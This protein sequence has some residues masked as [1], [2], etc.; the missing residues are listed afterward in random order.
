MK[1][2]MVVLFLSLVLVV[3]MLP[4]VRASG[5]ICFVGINDTIPIS[6]PAEEAPYYSGGTLYIPYT[7]FNAN[8]NGVVISN[9]VD[10]KTLVLFTRNSRLVYDLE[11]DTVT[12]EEDKTSKVTLLYKNGILFIPA[13]QAASHFGL[14]VTLLTSETGCPVLRFTN[15]QQVYSND[16]FVDKAEGLIHYILEHNAKQEA[17]EEE[18]TDSE[19]EP[20]EEEEPEDLGPATVYLA[21]AGNAVSESTLA[22]LD[23]VEICASFFLTE[24]QFLENRELVRSIYAA[25]HTIGLT[26]EEGEPDIEAALKAAN[27]A[28]DRILFC[29]SV[30]VLLPED[31]QLQGPYVR[32]IQ[33]VHMLQTDENGL[34]HENAPFLYVCRDDV[35]SVL[36]IL[37]ETETVTPQLLETTYL[38]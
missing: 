36:T 27:H 1:K 16:K 31:I 11:A 10:Q 3:T 6:L 4:G 17:M 12:D 19:A 8:P 38:P 32:R 21:F 14:S 7:A 2:R 15:G 29:K 26:V 20:E 23:A 13:V 37:R 30:Q 28:M 22:Y 5:L 34:V 9:N 18:N 33:R 35:A 25:G 24:K